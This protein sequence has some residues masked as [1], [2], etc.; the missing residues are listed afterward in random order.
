M[1]VEKS[2]VV[3]RTEKKKHTNKLSSLFRDFSW[4]LLYYIISM[5]LIIKDKITDIILEFYFGEKKTCPPLNSENSFLAKSA[6]ELAALIRNRKVTS[7]QLVEAT[8]NRMKEVNDVLNAI[9]DGPFEDAIEEAKKI[10]ERIAN[11]QISE[12]EF[13]AKPFLGVPFT[14]KDSTSVSGRL[15][16]LGLLARK[17]VTSKE[18]AECIALVKNAGGLIL[19]TTNIP[20]VNKWQETRNNLIGATNNPYDV[21]RTVGGS[22]GG[23][24]ALIS[25]CAS[26]FGI[27]TD[28][29]GSIRMPAF[30]CGIFGHKP[31]VG[32]INTRGC[33]FR[34]GKEPSTMVVA[35]PM[36]RYAKDLLP[37]L[38]IMADPKKECLLKLND[39]VDV[40]KLKYYYIRESGTRLNPMIE[41][42]KKLTFQSDLTM[43]AIYSLID[44]I[45]PK[46]KADKIKEITR[47]CDEELTNILGDD[48]ILL[49]H[50]MTRTAPFH[51]ALLFNVCD[52]SYWSIFNV[53]HVPATQ[54]PLGLDSKGLPLGVQVV[55]SRNRDR[56]CLAVAEELELAFGGWKPPFKL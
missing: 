3:I 17:N 48:G 5:V 22:S 4:K 40:R 8:I 37:L 12:D 21:R 47:K 30:Y 46:E 11:N 52:F 49:Y 54:V 35:G 9:V 43:G 20:E 24:G 44:E 10:D 16:T 6:I 18:D 2:K 41:L 34:T 1:C 19:A 39:K 23:E 29:G 27:G 42:I 31:T 51:Y 32:A 26:T 36:S 15:H 50:N 56:H 7:T 53:L 28:I 45:L 13:A 38:K 33:T 55:A 14:T 25:S